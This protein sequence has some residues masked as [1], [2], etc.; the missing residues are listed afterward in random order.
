M[1]FRTSQ[2]FE[3]RSS[4]NGN[5][6]EVDLRV[7]VDELYRF[8]YQELKK[9]YEERFLFDDMSKELYT[10]LTNNMVEFKILIWAGILRKQNQAKSE[11]YC[12]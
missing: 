5:R 6:D 3:N 4:L 1:M 12:N 10:E 11:N 9:I 8:S 7:D 2:N